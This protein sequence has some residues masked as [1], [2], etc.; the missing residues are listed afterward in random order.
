MRLDALGMKIQ[1]TAEISQFYWDAYRNMGDAQRVERDLWEINGINA[2]LQDL[3]DATTRLRAAYSDAW[4]K[5]NR[6]YWLGNVL[7]RYDNLASLVQAK[8]QAVEAAQA[9]YRE[10]LLLPSPQQMGF[11]LR[12]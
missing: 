1:F 5:E 3:R 7:V 6:S 8:I 4:L 9:Q 11:F 12:P 10:Q 2:R